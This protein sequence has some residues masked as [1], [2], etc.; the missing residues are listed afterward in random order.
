MTQHKLEWHAVSGGSDLP[1]GSAR[2]VTLQGQDIA[3]WRG[4]SGA[5]QAWRNQCPHRGMRLSFGQVRGERLS[6]RYHGWQFDETG[7]C[8][9]MPA[10]RESTPPA[11]IRV[12]SYGSMEAAGLIWVNLE[13]GEGSAFESGAAFGS[14]DLFCKSIYVASALEPLA[15]RLRTALP[16]GEQLSHSLLRVAA[17][18][19]EGP[20]DDL[21]IALQDMTDDR[22]G[23]HLVACSSGAEETDRQ[24]RLAV[25]RWARRLRT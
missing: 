9:F 17:S 11:S 13:G 21:V 24:T 4:A 22:C 3:I 10:H 1:A 8:A 23:L 18:Q 16:N 6:C 12:P 2:A 19:E 5:V 7:H 14:H 20:P 15:C 25:A